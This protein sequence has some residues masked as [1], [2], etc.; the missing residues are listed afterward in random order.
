VEE[1]V[2]S[3]AEHEDALARGGTPAEGPDT[4]DGLG[5]AGAR[6]PLEA[7]LDTAALTSPNDETSKVGSVSMLTLHSAKG[8]EFPVVFMVGMEEYTFPSK[9]AMES[10]E[11][12]A[13]EEERRLCYV[14]MTR[15]EKE[16]ILLAARQRRIYGKVEVRRPSRFIAELPDEIVG[17]LMEREPSTERS[18]ERAVD[19]GADR[20]VYD[21]ME[22]MQ[23]HVRRARASDAPPEV[24]GFHRGSRVFHNT[25]G[26]GTVEEAD[27]LGREARLTIRFPKAGV[28]RVVARFVRSLEES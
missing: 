9:R 13:I 2:S 25:F 23:P 14:G 20:I 26:E 24:Q 28:K 8:L 12:E 19:R 3:I 18:V 22:E 7:F 1:L 21:D 6:T 10:G 5:L 27:G 4:E 15:A 11:R 16:L 17:N